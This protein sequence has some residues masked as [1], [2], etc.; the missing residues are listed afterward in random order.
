MAKAIRVVHYLNQFFAGIGG[1]EKADVGPS[2]MEGPVGPG[3][4][5]QQLLG[6]EGEVVATVVC[7]DNYISEMPGFTEE[8]KHKALEVLRETLEQHSGDVVVAGPAFIDGRYGIGCGEMCRASW[9]AGVP[10]VTGMHPENVA[11]PLYVEDVYI[12]PTGDSPAEMGAVM[13]KLAYLVLKLGKDGKL[14]SPEEDGYIS[15]DG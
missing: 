9:S 4:L 8:H 3:R 13:K 5:L 15:P 1:D 11:T 7:G 10:A 2:A 6:D 12:V 14:G